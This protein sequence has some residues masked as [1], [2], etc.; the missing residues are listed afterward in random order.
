[1]EQPTDPPPADPGVKHYTMGGVRVEFPFKPYQA[2]IQ[3]M[4]K[5]VQAL[6]GGKNALLESPTGSGKS[7]AI[8]CAALAWKDYEKDR[9]SKEWAAYSELCNKEA[10]AQKA[11]EA[12]A[13]VQSALK[14]IEEA[15][16][17]QQGRMPSPP[18]P[19]KRPEPPSDRENS[20]GH[21][22]DD[23][24]EVP[25]PRKF[26]RV[27]HSD[28]PHPVVVIDDETPPQTERDLPPPPQRAKVPKI[29]V[30][31][32]THKQLS[33]LIKELKSNTRYRPK[34][35]VLGSRDQ[36]CINPKIIAAKDT[37]EACNIAVDKKSCI[38]K[39][40]MRKLAYHSALRDSPIF[41]IEDLCQ[42]GKKT[43]GCPYFAA[44]KVA[45]VADVVFCPYNYIIDPT[46]RRSLD[47][48]IKDSIIVLDEAH[49]I[50]D[51]A[52][53]AASYETAE[54]DLKIII[55]ELEQILR[56]NSKHKGTI[57][58]EDELVEAHRVLHY[59]VEAIQQWLAK[60]E[61]YSVGYEEKVKIWSGPDLLK[62]LASM[63]ITEHNFINSIK[64]KYDLAVKHAEEVRKKELQKED[65]GG[66]FDDDMG[67][68][69]DDMQDGDDLANEEQSKKKRRKRAYMS[70]KS[71]QTLGGLMVV[72]GYLFDPEH[73]YAEDY[74]MALLK[75]ISHD[76]TMSK[77]SQ[78]TY[79]VAFWCLNPGIIFRDISEAAHSVILTSGTLSPMNTFASE[80]E[81]EFP[82]RLEANHV[83]D[84]SQVWISSLSSGPS[85]VPYVGT[86]SNL[87]TWAYQDAVG[88]ALCNIANIIPY[89]VLCFMPSYSS[90]DKMLERWKNTGVYKKLAKK[91]Y[92]FR[93]PNGHKSKEVFEVLL[94]SYYQR[95]Q[96]VENGI[97]DASD[98]P[99][100]EDNEKDGALLFAVYRGK[101]SE[102]ID[103]TDNNCRAVV[104]LGIPFPNYKDQL[105]ELK[106][107]YNSQRKKRGDLVLDGHDWYRAQAFRAMNQAL[108]R[109]IRHSRDW[110]AVIL[111]ESRLAHA[112]NKS[113][114]SKWVRPL[115]IDRTDFNSAMMDLTLFSEQQQQRQ[116]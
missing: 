98:N 1:M 104:S 105:V 68:G 66:G 59:L 109:C 24:R 38:Y 34:T 85:H 77:E 72:L 101:V 12:E 60:A 7:L 115:C 74:R 84:R 114:L 87:N 52:R 71:I 49:N 112:Q 53:Q 64:P 20:A 17:L 93:E 75:N 55:V 111:L 107:D 65:Q 86:W 94:K 32:R 82:I 13:A 4:A 99:E 116:P 5:I 96:E 26:R 78:W 11:K 16:A 102:G 37:T 97:H 40:N 58:T 47:I 80:L 44:Q 62:E 88:D 63:S 76:R 43:K 28:T 14:L 90:L 91:K 113:Q 19:T 103:F 35:S 108:G 9:L 70:L 39:H 22:D 54:S 67:Y 29:Y 79:K 23:F 3:M 106:R 8:L 15:R 73:N 95:I 92:I 36:Y 50:E 89:G 100:N 42:L 10:D 18:V 41:D 46:V 48:N 6:K 21:D 81:T 30:G 33:Q 83:I 25:L 110:G 31:S 27:N 61:S 51:A 45:E 56:N 2:Q 69:M 57:A